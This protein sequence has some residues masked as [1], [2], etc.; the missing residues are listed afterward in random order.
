MNY[1]KTQQ[2]YAETRYREEKERLVDYLLREDE[3]FKIELQKSLQQRIEHIE[4]AALESQKI[5]LAATL[6]LVGIGVSFAYFMTGK[7]PEERASSRDTR[8][9]VLG[10]RL[11]FTS[12][13][14]RLGVRK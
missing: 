10:I 4:T 11:P 8:R 13:W 1:I 12:W 14:K 6:L 2:T 5:T 9:T 3:A 7:V